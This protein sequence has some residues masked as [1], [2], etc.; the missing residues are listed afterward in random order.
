[1]VC[2][3]SNYGNVGRVFFVTGVS[4]PADIGCECD[5]EAPHGGLHLAG[6]PAWDTGYCIN[7]FRPF[8]GPEQSALGL[9]RSLPT[10]EP[11]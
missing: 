4:E 5:D 6:F 7:C 8:Q 2:V 1:M 3:R 9:S 10:C 11:A